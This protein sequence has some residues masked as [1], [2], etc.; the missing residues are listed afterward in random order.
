MQVLVWLGR[1][2]SETWIILGSYLHRNRW[3]DKKT[4]SLCME[5]RSRGGATCPPVKL[6]W[7][8]ASCICMSIK[9][10]ERGPGNHNLLLR[11]SSGYTRF[12]PSCSS[13]SFQLISDVNHFLGVCIYISVIGHGDGCEQ[14]PRHSEGHY[15]S[16]CVHTLR[17]SVIALK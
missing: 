7:P 12:A 11:Q 3:T 5:D 13:L 16:S 17:T 2:V 1:E 9:N 4:Y 8:P 6:V 10:S 14:C 15:R